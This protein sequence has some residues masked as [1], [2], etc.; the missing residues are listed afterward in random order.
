MG[1]ATGCDADVLLKRT[2]LV[3]L[4]VVGCYTGDA[5]E[6]TAS[7][8]RNT[9]EQKV[10][11][12]H[13]PQDASAAILLQLTKPSE[14]KKSGKKA[15]KSPKKAAIPE[16]YITP[17]DTE[18]QP[19]AGTGQESDLAEQ[20][21]FAEHIE[22][23]VGAESPGVYEE[24]PIQE[25]LAPEEIAS[26]DV[27]E[28]EGSTPNGTDAATASSTDSSLDV[29]QIFADNDPASSITG[30][31]AQTEEA[32]QQAEAEATGAVGSPEMQ[33][34]HAEER[35]K[36]QAAQD[37]EKVQE[38]NGQV[39]KSLQEQQDIGTLAGPEAAAR[40]AQFLPRGSKVNRGRLPGAWG[41][42]NPTTTTTAG[43]AT[44]PKPYCPPKGKK[45]LLILEFTPG[46]EAEKYN[47]YLYSYDE[48]SNVTKFERSNSYL[49]DFG[50]SQPTLCCGVFQALKGNPEVRWINMDA[51]IYQDEQSTV[52]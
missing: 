40:A 52:F 19:L 49:L 4:M 34:K 27:A 36:A 32:K 48:F 18:I 11:C 41:K 42:L 14:K 10:A 23:A 6:S 21:G 50:R 29:W 3:V 45:C 33:R 43:P 24:T 20:M 44:T 28:D 51:P 2:L 31:A 46:Q 47:K 16:R 26:Q 22:P 1:A 17:A 12:W 38:L 13:E 15:S 9:F 7:T 30:P 5:V 8:L 35:R 39:A 25:Q 37:K